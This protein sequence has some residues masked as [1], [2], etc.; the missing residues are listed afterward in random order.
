M[1]SGKGEEE[2]DCHKKNKASRDAKE[3]ED[4]EVPEKIS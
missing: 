4:K 1:Q 3:D 2:E